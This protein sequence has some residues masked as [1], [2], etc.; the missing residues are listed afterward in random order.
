M[1]DNFWVNVYGLWVLFVAYLWTL[2]MHLKFQSIR[3]T[4]ACGS[5]NSFYCVIFCKLCVWLMKCLELVYVI[6][7]PLTPKRN[8]P[9]A[10]F[11]QKFLVTLQFFELAKNFLSY[12]FFSSCILLRVK[13][14]CELWALTELYILRVMW[15]I[16]ASYVQPFIE[17]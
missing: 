4:F 5:F 13:C 1:A 7:C 6:R 16:V 15:L 2:N 11:F 12:A 10:Q 3:I 9:M 14:R 17:L 8:R